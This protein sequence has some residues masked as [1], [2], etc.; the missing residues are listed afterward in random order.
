[1]ASETAATTAKRI[2]ENQIGPKRWCSGP[3]ELLEYFRLV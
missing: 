1:M 3:I 2:H